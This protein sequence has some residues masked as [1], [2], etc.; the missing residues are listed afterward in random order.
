MIDPTL[1]SIL[2]CP[3]TKKNLVLADAKLVQKINE[4]IKKG[5]VTNRSRQ[6]VLKEIDGG[7]FREGDGRFLYPIRNGIPILLVEELISVEGG[8]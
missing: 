1:L 2:V 4:D 7:L 5:K 6:K 3:E 8:T